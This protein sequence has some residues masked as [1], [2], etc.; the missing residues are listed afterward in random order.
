MTTKY[1]ARLNGKIV[2]KR[3]TANRTYTHAIVVQRVEEYARNAA[4]NRG[5]DWIKSD[6]KNF[7]YFV[8]KAAAGVSH[9][10]YWGDEATRAAAH[11]ADVAKVAAGIDA[12]L[13]AQRQASIASFEKGLA[14]G[15]YE[16]FVAAWAGRLD[17]A[18]KAVGQHTG[19]WC[20]LVAIVPAEEV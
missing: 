14:G 1:V 20:R 11:A 9:H 6:R 5:A 16:P 3:T 8:E 10:H 13:E 18:Q 15:R 2:G 12:Y 7:A 17:L 19:E 4:Y